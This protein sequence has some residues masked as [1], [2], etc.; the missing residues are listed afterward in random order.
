M[1]EELLKGKRSDWH[2][3]WEKQSQE[4]VKEAERFAKLTEKEKLEEYKLSLEKREKEIERKELEATSTQK[5]AKYEVDGLKDYKRADGT[6]VGL[7]KNETR[8]LTK[9]IFS[10]WITILFKTEE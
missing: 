2:K 7:Y 8:Q 3:E 4:S 1:V 9:G 6:G 5:V 10:K